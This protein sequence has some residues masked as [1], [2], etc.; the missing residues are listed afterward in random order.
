MFFGVLH[1]VGESESRLQLTPEGHTKSGSKVNISTLEER[2]ICRIQMDTCVGCGDGGLVWQEPDGA[3]LSRA[4]VLCPF[5]GWER[6]LG[7]GVSEE[8][9]GGVGVR[10]YS[11]SLS[12]SPS[13]SSAVGAIK[14]C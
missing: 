2:A 14:V 3:L 6:N 9:D 12:L 10:A 5:R 7:R 4:A 11:G 1:R 8:A 13:I